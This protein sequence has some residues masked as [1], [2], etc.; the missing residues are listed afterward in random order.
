[1]VGLRLQS[2]VAKS[3]VTRC[4]VGRAMGQKAEV[5]NDFE[6]LSLRQFRLNCV[7]GSVAGTDEK[8]GHALSGKFIKDARKLPKFF[9]DAS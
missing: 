1:M 4:H 3:D 8:I 6:R 7:N 9:E 2:L 5:G